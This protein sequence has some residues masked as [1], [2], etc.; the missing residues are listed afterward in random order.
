[1][2]GSNAAG[3]HFHAITR[4]E[5]AGGHVLDCQ[6]A[7]VTVEIDAIDSWRVEIAEE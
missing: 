5:N 1:M 4:D 2:A 3:Y 6:T 7:D